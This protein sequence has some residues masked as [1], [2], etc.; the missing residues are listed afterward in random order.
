M[1][2]QRRTDGVREKAE[3][4]KMYGLISITRTLLTMVKMGLQ[5]AA[6]IVKNPPASRRYRFN[7]WS[8]R[9]PGGGNENTNILAWEKD[10]WYYCLCS[11]KEWTQLST[12]RNMGNF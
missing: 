9:S 3:A 1:K 10:S 12:Y 7:P 5:V 11:H 8:A 4:S 6:A 2:E